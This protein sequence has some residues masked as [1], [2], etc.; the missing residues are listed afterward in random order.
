MESCVRSDYVVLGFSPE[1]MLW[2]VTMTLWNNESMSTLCN[3][4]QL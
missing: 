1:F 3:G 4:W 2:A